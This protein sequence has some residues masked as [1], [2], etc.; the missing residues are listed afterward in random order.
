MTSAA[1]RGLVIGEFDAALYPRHLGQR[2]ETAWL[3]IYQVLL[4]YASPLLDLKAL[5]AN[6]PPEVQA[7]VDTIE[8]WVNSTA[9]PGPLHIREA[10]DLK[11]VIWQKR[12]GLAEGFIAEALGVPAEDLPYLV[13]R[14]MRLPRWVGQQRN[15]PLGNGLRILVNEVLRRWG[16]PALGYHEEALATQWFPGIEMAGRSIKP[17]ID[18]A[19]SKPSGPVAIASCKWSIRHD[20]ISDPTNECTAYK[21]AAIQRQMMNL[22]YFVITNELDGQR[23]DKILNQPCVDALVHVHLDLVGHVTAETKLMQRARRDGRLLD[24]ADFVA[25]THT[26]N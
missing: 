22:R 11:K 8:Q 5:A 1:D 13:D 15:N 24:L 6:G 20:R 4:W 7:A 17:S 3:G 9:G 25:L 14:M 10:N 19:I 16:N 2:P 23:L 26:W 21:S 18:V 12:A